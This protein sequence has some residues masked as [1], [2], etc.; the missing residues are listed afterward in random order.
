[1]SRKKKEEK[2]ISTTISAS[3]NGIR[4][5]PRKIRLVTD[6]IKSKKIQEALDILKYSSKSSI[7]IFI[8]KLILSSL[9]NWNKKYMK[10]EEF[11]LNNRSLSNSLYIKNIRVNQGKTLK[12]L[13]PVP[14]GRGH[15]IR[16]R[17][18]NVIIILD[19]QNR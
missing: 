8:K 18:S 11:S 1:M 7:S 14:Q 17:S 5:S 10:K 2:N 15:R 3:L 19:K 9:S 16:K 13:R 6:L 4:R 12:R